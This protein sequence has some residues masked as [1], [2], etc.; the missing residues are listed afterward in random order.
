MSTWPI[1]GCKA[2]LLQE[3]GASGR[4]LGAAKATGKDRLIILTRKAWRSGNYSTISWAQVKD[5]WLNPPSRITDSPQVLWHPQVSGGE[6]KIRNQTGQTE[7]SRCG[8]TDN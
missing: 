2:R 1:A 8:G 3:L 4:A 6:L 7:H 5:R